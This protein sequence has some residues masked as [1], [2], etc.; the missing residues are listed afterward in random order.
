M[1]LTCLKRYHRLFRGFCL[2]THILISWMALS[3]SSPSFSLTFYSSH[4][5]LATPLPRFCFPTS[6]SAC[7][8]SL[9]QLSPPQNRYYVFPHVSLLHSTFDR[10]IT[11]ICDLTNMSPLVDFKF[12]DFGSVIAIVSCM[13]PGP[14]A[15]Y[16]YLLKDCFATS[17]L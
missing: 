9:S 7:P 11:H 15:L 12:I 13:L 3:A 1:I 8:Q 17:T 14:Q 5:L 4:L 2:M 10:Y 6:P 16:Q